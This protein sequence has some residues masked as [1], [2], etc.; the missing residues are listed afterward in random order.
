M[1]QEGKIHYS[2]PPVEKYTYVY[3]SE[4]KEVDISHE[5]IRP[6][7]IYYMKIKSKEEVCTTE[8]E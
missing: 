7:K 3:D 8:T 2:L 4:T 6:V 5:T 1:A